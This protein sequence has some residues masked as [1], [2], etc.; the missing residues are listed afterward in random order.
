MQSTINAA[1]SLG[2]SRCFCQT[3]DKGTNLKLSQ[4]PNMT[5][6]FCPPFEVENLLPTDFEFS[7][8]DKTTGQTYRGS[9]CKGETAY[10]HN[11]HSGSHVAISLNLRDSGT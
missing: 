11:I 1:L 9:V 3:V 10:L 8:V 4:Y 5:L 6:Q 7:I 2:K